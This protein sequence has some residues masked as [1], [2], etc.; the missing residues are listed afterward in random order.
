MEMPHLLLVSCLVMLSQSY[1][2][3][4]KQVPPGAHGFPEGR[5]GLDH[6]GCFHFEC[7]A[8]WKGREGNILECF[9]LEQRVEVKGYSAFRRGEEDKPLVLASTNMG[10][11]ELKQ[12]MACLG[13]EFES[14]EGN[15]LAED[16]AEEDHPDLHDYLEA[17]DLALAPEDW[18]SVEWMDE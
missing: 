15:T 1:V 12:L 16:E 3:R 17:L 7:E 5:F 14:P 8:S 13:R 18:D 11:R 10:Y 9:D 4:A 2:A 6:P